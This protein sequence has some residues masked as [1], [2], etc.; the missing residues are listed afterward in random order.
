MDGLIW[1]SV[2]GAMTGSSELT[3]LYGATL[4]SN[5]GSLQPRYEKHF[6]ITVEAIQQMGTP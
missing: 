4:V 5:W 2:P 1:T 3:E 6:L